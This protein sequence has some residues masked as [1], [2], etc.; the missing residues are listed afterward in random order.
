MTSS[1]SGDGR[2]YCDGCCPRPD[3]STRTA[4]FSKLMATQ[5]G[6]A[7][8]WLG[9][10][11]TQAQN[12]NEP[13]AKSDFVGDLIDGNGIWHKDARSAT[14]VWGLLLTFSRDSHKR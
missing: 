8:E 11:P 6:A 14:T 1:W 12:T 5:N 2:G 3:D 9:G 4:H 10:S 13:I 7:G